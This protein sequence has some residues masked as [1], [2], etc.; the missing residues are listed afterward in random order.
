MKARRSTG[1]PTVRIHLLVVIVAF[2][3]WCG[4]GDIENRDELSASAHTQ[5][6]VSAATNSPAAL[7]A[8]DVDSTGVAAGK[9]AGTFGVS[10]DGQATYAIPIWVPP[11][12]LG[13]QPILTVNYHSRGP[14]GPVGIGWSLDGLLRI[15][16]CPHEPSADQFSGRRV[17]FDAQDRL[18]LNGVRLIAVDG[19]AY[20]ANGAVYRTEDD[21]H[22]KVVQSGSPFYFSTVFKV[23]FKDGRISTLGDGTGANGVVRGALYGAY[24]SSVP[25]DVY[26]WLET[27]QEDR[28]GNYLSVQYESRRYD[29]GVEVLPTQIQL[30][31]WPWRSVAESH[32]FLL[33]RR[34]P[35]S[36]DV[37][38]WRVRECAEETACFDHRVWPG[39][40]ADSTSLATP[41][42]GHGPGRPFRPPE[43]GRQSLREACSRACVNVR[44]PRPRR[45]VSARPRS[46]TSPGASASPRSRLVVPGRVNRGAT[47]PWTTMVMARTIPRRIRPRGQRLASVD[48][49][50]HR[51]QWCRLHRSS[52]RRPDHLT[53]QPRG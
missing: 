5:A 6:L 47:L 46:T 13:V 7:I 16:R 14:D 24:G 27:K 3:A 9:T 4:R 53:D 30:R 45:S 20:N 52:G 37:V 8:T 26:A 38:H 39:A 35:R 10:P 28:F 41:T 51:V 25:D 29:V 42:W 48:E 11:G 50:G 34:S 1:A 32:R 18:C 22:T 15:E 31:R 12:R 36:L 21:I 19:T 17:S 43:W 49:L 44:A 2:S 33:L 23:Y 40:R